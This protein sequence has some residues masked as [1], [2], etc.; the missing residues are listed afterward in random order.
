MTTRVKG[1]KVA[2]VQCAPVYLDRAATLA[3]VG[4]KLAEAAKAGAQLVVFPEAFVP[5]YPEWVWS[6][7]IKERKL[8]DALYAELV[9]NSIAVPGPE[10]GALGQAARQ[11]GVTS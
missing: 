3:V 6:V 9:E 2:A 1:F 10:V 11:A 8:H 4:E 7:P 5:G